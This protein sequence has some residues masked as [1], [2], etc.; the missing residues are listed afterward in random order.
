MSQQDLPEESTAPAAEEE[1]MEVDS[2]P[3]DSKDVETKPETAPVDGEAVLSPEEEAMMVDDAA[4]AD[5]DEPPAEK[6]PRKAAPINPEDSFNNFMRLL[7]KTENLARCLTTGDAM[8]KAPASPTKPGPSSSGDHRHRM[9]EKEEDEELLQQ[10]KKT[11]SLLLFNQS[12]FYIKNGA[13]RDYQIRGL[14][15]MVQ[16]QHNSINGI[17]ADEMGLGKTL[18]TISLLGYMKHVKNFNGPFLVIVPKSTLQNWM[19]EFEK[20]CPTMRA[21]C[22]IGNAEDRQRTIN[23]ELSGNNWDVLV[24][25]YEM[26]LLATAFCRKITWRYIVIDEAHRIKNENSKLSQIVRSLRSKHRLLLTG[27]PLQNNLHELWALLN[28]LMPEMF[29]N[30]EDFDSWLTVSGD[31]DTQD[32]VQRLHRILQPFLLRRIKADVEKSLLPKKELKIYIGL[33]QMQ[34]EWYTKILMKD[35]DVVNGAGKIEKTR[36]MNILMHLRKCCNHPYLFDGAEPGPPFTTDEHLINNCG[37]MVLLDKLLKRLKEQG[38]RVLIF[39]SMTRMLDMLEDYCW[40]RNYQYCRLDGQTAH[41]DR[42]RAINEYN[43][44]GSEKFVFMLTTR[45]GGLGINLTTADVVVI[46][47]S[48]W[49]PQVDLQAMDR[50]HR[51]GQKKQVRVF[52]LITESTIEERIIERAEMKLRLD[53]VVIQQ[54]RLAEAQKTLGKDDMLTMIRHGADTIFAG[55]DSTITE[56]DIDS[57][58][59]QGEE[60]TKD[61]NEKMAKLGESSLR[62]FTLDTQQNDGVSVYNWQGEDYRS[63]QKQNVLDYWIEPPKRERKA[64]YQVDNYFREAMKSGPSDNNKSTKAPRPKLPTVYD[65]Q[66]YPKRLFEIFDK[67]IYYFRKQL[68]YQAVKPADLTGK[69]AERAQK[70]EQKK[71]DEAEPPTEEEMAEREELLKQ[72]LSNWSRKD[73]TSFVKASERYGRHDLANIA[74]EVEGKT[75]EEVAEYSQ[76]FWENIEDLTDHERILGQI[77]RGEQRIERR[78]GIILALDRKIAKYKAPYHQLRLPY[79]GNKCKNYNEEEDRFLVCKL[80]ELGYDNDTVYEEVRQAIRTAPQFRFDW[81]MKSRTTAEVQRR[82]QALIAMIEKEME[83]DIQEEKDKKKRGRKSEA[84]TPAATKAAPPAKKTPASKKKK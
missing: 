70:E 68:K 1:P 6:K 65:F 13:L 18:Q 44:E 75:P 4:D 57:I 30:A 58:L 45:A 24:T 79:G 29:A 61:M 21:V 52:R 74:L 66:F 22:L 49:N 11:D 82:C 47:D 69:E 38:S 23:E 62:N 64:N 54:G 40:F 36:L 31:R 39:S 78:Q 34:R 19:N 83:R 16:L 7:Q 41:E 81:F 12:P 71:I 48:D 26:I 67:E 20:W 28:F 37:K 56:D 33:S 84:A 46:Y 32:I 9:T 8:S 73:F 27:T 80:H 35:I 59:A 72:G 14:N 43:A 5:Y 17:L 2:H 10:S 15:W 77:E 76:I 51:I 53:N 63:K 42:Q 50:A 3:E 25:S 60:R 55:K